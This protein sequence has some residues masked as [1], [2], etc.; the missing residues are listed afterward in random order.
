MERASAARALGMWGAE[1]SDL[2]ADSGPAVCVCAALGPAPVKRPH[3]L[4]VLLD[5]LRDP[6]TTDS[7]FP[8]R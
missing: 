7:W 5:A 3:A 1:I 2:L 8:V 6:G 4:A